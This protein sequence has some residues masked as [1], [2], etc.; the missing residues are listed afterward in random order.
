MI[1][2]FLENFIFFPGDT[3]FSFHTPKRGGNNSFIQQLGK[4]RRSI[5]QTLKAKQIT[6]NTM[7]HLNTTPAPLQPYPLFGARTMTGPTSRISTLS[8]GT[9]SSRFTLTKRR[10]S[11]VEEADTLLVSVSGSSIHHQNE[12]GGRSLFPAVDH[13]KKMVADRDNL[14]NSKHNKN[15]NRKDTSMFISS[16]SNGSRSV[17]PLT[18]S[19]TS[20]PVST[21][22]MI[23]P[24]SIETTY[25]R[26]IDSIRSGRSYNDNKMERSSGQDSVDSSGIDSIGSNNSSAHESSKRR[27][28]S[29]ITLDFCLSTPS[30]SS[31]SSFTAHANSFS[32]VTAPAAPAMTVSTSQIPPAIPISFHSPE[33]AV[34]VAN[35]H[36]SITSPSQTTTN[37]D[38]III[39]N[40]NHGH[41]DAMVL[42]AAIERL[43]PSAQLSASNDNA[44]NNNDSGG[45]G[46]SATQQEEDDLAASIALARQLMQEESMQAAHWIQQETL[47]AHQQ[48]ARE[49]ANQGIEGEQDEDL[50]YALELAAQEQNAAEHDVPDDQDFD[51]EEMSYDD[52][53]NLGNRIGDVA[54]QRWQMDSKHVIAGFPTKEL[55][56]TDIAD[57]KNKAT[58]TK[59]HLALLVVDPT[60][61]QICQ[62]DFEC[63][64]HIKILPCGHDFHVG[65]IDMWLKDNKTCCLCKASVAPEDQKE[66]SSSTS[67]SSTSS[68]SSPTSSSSS[69]ETKR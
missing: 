11:K 69:G 30:T 22:S 18:M 47:A 63:T 50:M 46:I 5:H 8:S 19:N 2:V 67:S 9:S 45:G 6:P 23:A 10:N 24:S 40:T 26:T 44:S 36:T 14:N 55:T 48:M 1:T 15:E 17:S 34:V 31:G 53:M 4:N 68:S 27:M 20:P 58:G 66:S 38:D 33:T 37:D 60:I 41:V 64:E 39:T 35:P 16:S 57:R 32:S 25:K 56:E 51:V 21:L 28:T 42:N 62:C 3:V 52:L 43:T 7:S 65:C 13:L 29:P 61:C 54:Q 12:N 59:S 49:M